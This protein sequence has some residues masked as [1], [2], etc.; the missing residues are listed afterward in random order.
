MGSILAS[1]HICKIIKFLH[2]GI[3]S[4]WLTEIFCKMMCLISCTLSSPKSHILAL[5]Y[6]FGGF[7]DSS[8]GKQSACNA[9][10]SGSIPGFERSA[11]EAISYPIQYSW[12]S[13]TAQLIKNPPAMRETCVWSQGWEDPLEK[14]K[15][16]HCSI[17]AWRI[18][19]TA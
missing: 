17:L 14:G 4:S 11:G 12:A 15:A 18:P 13:L 7:L 6:V 5:P 3:H 8:I 2:S 9:G 10:D 16:T 1:P 19:W